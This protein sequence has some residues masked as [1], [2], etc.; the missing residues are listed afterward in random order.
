[1]SAFVACSTLIDARFKWTVSKADGGGGGLPLA[2]NQL[3]LGDAGI[4]VVSSEYATIAAERSALENLSRDLAQRIVTR[5]ALALRE[6][7]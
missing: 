3:T 5:V 4:D 6:D 7:R 1:M 2:A